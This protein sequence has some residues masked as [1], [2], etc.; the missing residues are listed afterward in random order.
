M[1]AYTRRNRQTGTLLTV[2]SAKRQ[3]LD[4][5][6]GAWVT[7]CE[8]HGTLVNSETRELAVITYP[9]DFCD[10]CRRIAGQ[11]FGDY[12]NEGLDRELA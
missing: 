2:D 8:P 10:L 7:I 5:D 3:G 12:H 11:D 6:G 9:L 4:D 1:S